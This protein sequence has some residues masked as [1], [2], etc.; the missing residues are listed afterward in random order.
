M[1]TKYKIAISIIAIVIIFAII[2]IFLIIWYKKKR[3]KE[4][5]LSSSTK[6]NSGV[7]I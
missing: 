3:L 2:G 1:E 5:I 6:T 4:I 7:I